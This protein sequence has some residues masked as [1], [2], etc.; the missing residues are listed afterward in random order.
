VPLAFCFALRVVDV[1]QTSIHFFGHA[2]K[3]FSATKKLRC[4]FRHA[5]LLDEKNFVTLFDTHFHCVRTKNFVTLLGTQHHSAQKK[6]CCTTLLDTHHQCVRKKLCYTFRHAYNFFAKK[7]C[8]TFR[9]AYNF[10]AKKNFVTLFDTRISARTHRSVLCMHRKRRSTIVK[11]REKICYTSRF[12]RV[13]L[14]QGPC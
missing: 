6:L 4:T 1:A 10:Y 5:N 9:H 12:V 14:A 11:K 3:T 7:L 8:Y 2:R 13:I